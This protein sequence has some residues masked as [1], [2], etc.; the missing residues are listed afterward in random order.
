MPQVFKISETNFELARSCADMAQLRGADPTTVLPRTEWQ[1]VLC[2]T[3]IET[4][5]TMAGVA[6]TVPHEISPPNLAQM[7][8]VIGIAGNIRAIFSL[9][10][11]QKCAIDIASKMLGIAPDDPG[12]EKAASDAV[13]EVCN[14][15][16]GYFK[17]K[18]G[19]GDKGSLS[20][21]TIVIGK[22][23]T[24][25]LTS[26][27]ERLEFPLLFEGQGIWFTLDIRE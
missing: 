15:V 24:I 2:E 7:T 25:H 13:G 11:S 3:V 1:S 6:V 14:V 4:F 9:R 21:P 22:S 5:S 12:A 17:A 16:A 23:Y 18:I 26:G 10:C 20:L 19:L 8:G 27:C